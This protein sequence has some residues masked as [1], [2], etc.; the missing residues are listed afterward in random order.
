MTNS[1]LSNTLRTD[2]P[3]LNAG[4]SRRLVKWTAIFGFWIFF[5]LLNASQFYLGMRMEG[6]PAPVGRM[7][8]AQTL[9]WGAW[10][11]LTP[12]VLWLGRRFPLERPTL[13]R[14][15]L[16][17]RSEEHTS[18]LQSR[19]DLV[20]RLLLEKKNLTFYRVYSHHFERRT[21]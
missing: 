5:G 21:P 16:V 19:S 17:H 9:G 18:E 4:A 10:A 3:V 15:L 8:A 2:A 6:F 7:L 11:F 20:C 14:G 1:Y 13:A 12:L